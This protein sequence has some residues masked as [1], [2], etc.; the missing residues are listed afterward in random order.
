[1][2]LI[3]PITILI[4]LVAGAALLMT[5]TK[6][7]SMASLGVAASFLTLLMSV[8]IVYMTFEKLPPIQ[9]E[10]ATVVPALEYAPS[11]L[12]FNLPV[13]LNGKPIRWQL[14][15]GVD[16]IGSLMVFLTG[17]VGFV[18]SYFALFQ[19]RERIQQYIALILISQSLLLGVFMSM[20]L[21][22]F[23]L[24]F[25]AIL[26]PLMLLINGW[27]DGKD[28]LAASKKFLLFTLAGSIPMVMGLIGLAMQ[29]AELSGDSTVQL[30]ALSAFAHQQQDNAL[31]AGSGMSQLL[32][33]QTWILWLLLLG[34][35]IKM[36]VLPLHTWLPTTYAAAHPNTTALIASVVAK[37]GVFGIIRIVLPLTPVALASS[38]QILFGFLGAIAI[39]YGALVA[40]SQSEL[41]KVFAYSS[42]SHMG[43][44]TLGLMSLNTDGMTGASIQMLNHGIIT[45]AMFLILGML[46]QRHQNLSFKMEDLGMSSLY[47]K[48]GV[49]LVFFT[50]AGAGLPGLNGF[51]GEILAMMGMIRVSG[52]ITAIAVLGTVLG[53]WYALRVVQRTLFGSDGSRTKPVRDGIG[54][55][56]SGEWIVLGMLAVLCLYIGVRPSGP[57]KMIENDVKRL[58]QVT[59]PANKA[60][61]PT[62][63]TLAQLGE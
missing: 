50:L 61:H 9:G 56:S 10:L 30:Q 41:R 21:L 14:M 18:V 3:V 27:G 39:V 16:G 63:D 7:R 55:C 29:S 53:A 47:P 32:G 54:D 25:E 4:P 26:I 37:L 17:L 31:A 46:E 59:E 13:A 35:G 52:V 36:A 51:V 34:F 28:T 42:I 58:V 44:V 60:S 48:I 38:A 1:M 40:L 20:D 8:L 62:V 22:S 15:L 12:K 11:W 5:G 19:I 6:G 57:L 2:N 24:F 33:N 23:Y 43:F 49:L 45:C